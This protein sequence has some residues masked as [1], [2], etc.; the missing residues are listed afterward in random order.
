MGSE[1]GTVP[2]AELAA[3][4]LHVDAVYQG[5]R[6]GNAGD[7][8]FPRLL[9][10]SNMG[11]FRYRGTLAALEMVVLTSTL[12]D[13]DWPDEL[14]RETGAF[15]YYGDNKSPGRALHATPRNGNELLRRI[16]A[17]AHSGDAGRE[18]V[19]P[20]LVF[21]NTGE[22]RDVMFLGLAVPGTSEQQIA[23]D[24]VA[25]WRTAEGL[26]FQNYRA[27]LTILDAPLIPRAW[28]EDV[29]AGQPHTSNAPAAWRDFIKK[30][31]YRPLKS[32]RSIEYR[33]KAEQIP[34]NPGD[35]AIIGT[36]HQFFAGRPHDFER[37]AAVI[38]RMMLPDIA[39]LDLTRPS[40]DGGRDAVGRVR[41][42]RG[43]GSILVDFALEA[44]C[45]GMANSVGVREMSRLIS[46][47]RHRQFGILVT[48]SFVDLQAYQEIKEDQHPII[49]IAAADIV[50]L[51]R[52]AGHT[53]VE[54][55][56][57]WLERE[58]SSLPF[59]S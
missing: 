48:T 34:A 6:V 8:P 14:D 22:W 35:M 4:D 55:V 12:N 45:Y 28:I 10:V 49:V 50:G 33:S 25:I 3:A 57:L 56:K 21:S 59:G 41:L 38:A 30:G 23:E 18:L 15:T 43:P 1:I 46:R 44:K 24:L 52:V 7:D 54:N 47:L 39:E 53:D 58:F 13:P 31:K 26:R 42:G 51:L 2:F 20:I 40:R 5:G 36:V 9:K 16:F 19:P 37:Y 11:G 17:S 29:I 27:R 32:T